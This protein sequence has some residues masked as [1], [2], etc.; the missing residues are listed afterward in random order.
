MRQRLSDRELR[1]VVRL[2]E[3]LREGGMSM[4]LDVEAA[5][6]RRVRMLPAPRAW[7]PVVSLREFGWGAAAAVAAITIGAVGLLCAFSP[8]WLSA[9][10]SALSGFA[11]TL[12]AVGSAAWDILRA[13]MVGALEA[14]A[15]F[16]GAASYL[17]V[18]LAL[19]TQAALLVCIGMVVLTVVVLSQETRSRRL[20]G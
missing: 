16:S 5:V 9:P 11:T 3:T 14:L 17:D 6:E 4:D 2:L 20:T 1:R 15:R 8:E 13:L 12:A 7:M 10:R 18:S 19:A